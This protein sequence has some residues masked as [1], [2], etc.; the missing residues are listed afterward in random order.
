MSSRS[1]SSARNRRAGPNPNIQ[2]TLTSNA[3]SYNYGSNYTNISRMQQNTTS[4]NI[5]KQE[6]KLLSITQAFMLINGKI[7]NLENQVDSMTKIIETH[8]VTKSHSDNDHSITPQVPNYEEMSDVSEFN[9]QNIDDD[10]YDQDSKTSKI[11]NEQTMILPNENN[12]N[13]AN[14]HLNIEPNNKVMFDETKARE[15]AENVTIDALK[16]Y[17]EKFNDINSKNMKLENE[18]NKLNNDGM[19]CK[20]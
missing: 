20:E 10:F 15:V 5:D 4:T 17:D 18:Y 14:N 8:N 19:D 12:E 2:D 16:N 9:K 3:Q 1:N 7:R 6:H 11:D 13:N